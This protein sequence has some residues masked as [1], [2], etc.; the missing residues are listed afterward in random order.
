MGDQRLG[1]CRC[2]ADAPHVDHVPEAVWRPAQAHASRPVRVLPRPLLG[3]RQVPEAALAQPGRGNLDDREVLGMEPAAR[4]ARRPVAVEQLGLR[5]R[6]ELGQR[7]LV[8]L[9]VEV[10]VVS[11]QRADEASAPAVHEARLHPVVAWAARVG[12]GQHPE[13]DAASDGA[14]VAAEEVGVLRLRELGQLVEGDR[15][16]LSRVVAELGLLVL[17]VG[18][19]QPAAGR[20][21]EELL[22]LVP[23]GVG[24]TEPLQR[25]RD[26]R[27]LQL[28]VRAAEVD[29][30]VLRRVGPHQMSHQQDVRLAAAGGA[31]EQ[32]LPLRRHQEGGL[33]QGRLMR[34]VAAPRHPP[35]QERRFSHRVGGVRQRRSQAAPPRPP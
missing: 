1:A 25:P 22:L 34:D 5:H 20:E 18:E 31:A 24:L 35:Q 19:V 8:L 23:A 6:V 29:A 16:V 14:P 15:R 9:A 27:Q 2:L 7:A 33:G 28:R 21:A 32:P 13:R 4:G 10:R 11:D 12:A 3:R 17:Q 26:D 30:V